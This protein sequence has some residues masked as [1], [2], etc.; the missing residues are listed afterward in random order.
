MIQRHRLL[1][2]IFNFLKA[3]EFLKKF[4][5]WTERD[6]KQALFGD[7]NLSSPE[8][9]APQNPHLILMTD[10]AAR[11]NPG[12]AGIG[13]VLQTPDG[14]IVYRFYQ[15]IGIQT[16]NVAEYIA[17]KTG[18][19]HALQHHPKELEIRLDSELVVKQI[20][21]EYKTKNARLREIQEEIFRMLER[22]PKWEIV[23]VPRSANRL[24]DE[25]ANKAINTKTEKG[26]V[27]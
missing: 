6:L 12:E 15:Y 16:N 19:Q 26:E 1:Q 20:R 2:D 23:H 11:G 25:L 7:A 17:L 13:V 8:A 27:L 18:L 21:G 3:Q 24:A 4:P 10:G 9:S 22:I 5:Q 14:E